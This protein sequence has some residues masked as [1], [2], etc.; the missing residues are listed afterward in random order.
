MA[1][2]EDK[3]RD[4][5]RD[6]ESVLGGKRGWKTRAAAMLDIDASTISRALKGSR[7]E[8]SPRLGAR[9]AA[10]A[11]LDRLWFFTHIDGEPWWR[12]ADIEPRRGVSLFFLTLDNLE[13]VAVKTAGQ[14]ATNA[15]PDGALGR[16]LL[17]QWESLRGVSF[18][19][20][21]V[22]TEADLMQFAKDT[23]EFVADVRGYEFA[24]GSTDA[25]RAFLETMKPW[26]QARR[27]EEP[28]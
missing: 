18:V 6:I 28:K 26:I 2:A 15:L 24:R 14:I 5:L 20:A 23:V 10:A 17:D 16:E 19:R 22:K 4:L 25:R 8:L 12:V 21:G 1:Q 7:W 27:Q 3:F 13:S 11:G 9:V